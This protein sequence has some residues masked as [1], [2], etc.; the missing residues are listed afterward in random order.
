MVRM[1]SHLWASTSCV[2]AVLAVFLIAAG[3]E[4]SGERSVKFALP[5]EDDPEGVACSAFQ[6]GFPI[7]AR[8]AENA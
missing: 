3:C 5:A 8:A 6:R 2:A 7:S 1:L 4:R